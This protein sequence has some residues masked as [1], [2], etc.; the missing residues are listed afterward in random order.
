MVSFHVAKE[1]KCRWE[2]KWRVRKY[3]LQAKNV[4]IC[5]DICSNVECSLRTPYLP[6]AELVGGRVLY[7]FKFH[8][9]EYQSAVLVK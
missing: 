4:G 2:A 1:T 9:D 5:N 7:T 6:H 3:T 8:H